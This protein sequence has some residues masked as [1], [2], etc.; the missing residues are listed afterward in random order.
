MERCGYEGKITN[1]GAQCV[2]APNKQPKS[3]A[4]QTVT[5]GKDLRGNAGSK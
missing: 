2:E 4:D 5:T 3:N 1:A